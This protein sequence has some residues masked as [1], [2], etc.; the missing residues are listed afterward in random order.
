MLSIFGRNFMFPQ[1]STSTDNVN[2]FFQW[3]VSNKYINVKSFQM[4]K[5]ENS[6]ETDQISSYKISWIPEFCNKLVVMVSYY[7]MVSYDNQLRHS[8]F[9]LITHPLFLIHYPLIYYPQITYSL[10]ICLFR[11]HSTSRIISCPSL[12]RNKVYNFY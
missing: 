6:V 3:V 7:I 5:L 9:V 1:L 10:P 8:V 4:L 2:V 11:R 12:I